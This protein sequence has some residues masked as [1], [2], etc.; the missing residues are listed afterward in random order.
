MHTFSPELV[1]TM[2]AA[3]EEAEQLPAILNVI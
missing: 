1:E 3:F 2:R